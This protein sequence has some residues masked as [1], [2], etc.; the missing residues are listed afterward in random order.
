MRMRDWSS[1]VC[2]SV[3][4]RRAHQFAD[5]RRARRIGKAR[6]GH[7]GERI[8]ARMRRQEIVLEPPDFAETVVPELEPAIGGEHPERLEQIVEGRGAYAQQ[9]V[10]RARKLH[11]LGA[12]L[13]SEEHTS[14]LQSLMR[15]SYAVFCLKKKTIT[16][17]KTHQYS[18]SI[19]YKLHAEKSTAKTEDT[20]ETSVMSSNRILCSRIN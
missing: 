1:D 12:I 15:I 10:A 3:L 9:R 5:Q 14:E 4:R 6:R 8:D 19:K 18:Q 16:I 20:N 17:N 2:S 11:L 7:L 13:R